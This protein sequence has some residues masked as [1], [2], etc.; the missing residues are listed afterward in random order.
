MTLL[1]PVRSI[2]VALMAF[3]TLAGKGAAQDHDHHMMMGSA[4]LKAQVEGDSFV[5]EMG[6]V[7]LP[8]HADHDAIR[9][10]MPQAIQVGIDGWL[11]GY[12]IELLDRS[13]KSVPQSVVHHVNVI[14]PQKRE[15]FS[16]IMLRVAA[17]GAETAPVGLPFFMGYEVKKADTMLVSA[18]LHNESATSYE[19]VR[20]R[21]KLPLTKR[22]VLPSMGIFPF[23][24]DVMPPAGSH[25]FDLPA[26]RSERYWEGS[27]AVPG[28]ILGLSGH[29]HKYGTLLRLEDRTSGKVIWEGSPTVDDK[30]EVQAMPLKKFIATFGVGI[31]PK[32][33]YR[34][35][36]VYDNPTGAPVIDGGMGALGGVFLPGDGVVW[37]GVDRQN[38]DYVLDWRITWR[39]DTSRDVHGSHK[40]P[41]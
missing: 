5:L 18:M 31:N 3:A 41:G 10:P 38:A 21:V 19:G 23:Y 35:T 24:M 20:L 22:R 17:A 15:L 27:P 36:A 2:V 14:M 33:V 13:G 8:A 30:G 12:S 40:G 1:L 34:L 16:P 39:L 4:S 11:R 29:L 7:D 37:P 9:Q 25:S 28:R 32:H 6:P 26:G